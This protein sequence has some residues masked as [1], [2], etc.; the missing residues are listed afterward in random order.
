[1]TSLWTAWGNAKGSF[2]FSKFLLTVLM[3]YIEGIISITNSNQS[4]LPL[5]LRKSLETAV[6]YGCSSVLLILI[7]MII[8]AFHNNEF[9]FQFPANICMHTTHSHIV[10]HNK[11]WPY[12][13]LGA[14]A[15]ASESLSWFIGGPY[16]RKSI[17]CDWIYC[18]IL[19]LC[20]LINLSNSQLFSWISSEYLTPFYTVLCWTL[21]LL[22]SSAAFLSQSEVRH[23]LV[24]SIRE[25]CELLL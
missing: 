2:N 5:F 24:H 4:G 15:E 25:I 22:F 7:N 10:I 13:L 21:H 19:G 9:Y 8:W 11:T 17:I 16:K 20:K 1:M 14:S 18:C 23:W 3:N 12:E 6:L